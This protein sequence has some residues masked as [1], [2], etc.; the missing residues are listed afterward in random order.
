MIYFTKECV[1]CMERDSTVLFKPC[2]HMCCCEQC[3]RDIQSLELSCPICRVPVETTTFNEYTESILEQVDDGKLSIWLDRRQEYIDTLKQKI[4]IAGN[5]GMKGRG[6]LARAVSNA[7]S[8]AF[9]EAILEREGADRLG[10]K[11]TFQIESDDT[12]VVTRT[13]SKKKKPVVERYP[14]VDKDQ[15]LEDVRGTECCTELHLATYDPHIFHLFQYHYNG[16]VD[17]GMDAAGILQK[18]RIRRRN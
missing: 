16:Q 13:I 14:L 8:D 11:T 17:E 5:G 6:K 3:S 15:L 7:V 10:S 9:A 1:V 4:R 12:L 2:N 18:K